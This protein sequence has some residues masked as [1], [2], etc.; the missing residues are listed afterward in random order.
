MTASVMQMGIIEPVVCRQDE[1]TG[2]GYV[3]AGNGLKRTDFWT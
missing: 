3:V 2:L 1:A